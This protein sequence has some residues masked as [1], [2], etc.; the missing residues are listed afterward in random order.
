MS[1]TT[2]NHVR[3]MLSLMAQ[4]DAAGEYDDAEAVRDPKRGKV[5]GGFPLA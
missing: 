3:K 2:D 5:W 4:A 1:I